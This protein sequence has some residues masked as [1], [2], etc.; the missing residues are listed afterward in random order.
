[1]SER[2]HGRRE[3]MS[4][5]AVFL[6]QRLAAQVG[7][8]GAIGAASRRQQQ[9]TRWS[10]DGASR[11]RE[12]E[13]SVFFGHWK[14]SLRKGT[15]GLRRCEVAPETL[16]EA[17]STESNSTR[18]PFLGLYLSFKTQPTQS[19]QERRYKIKC[20]LMTQ[21]EAHPRSRNA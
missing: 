6:R 13:R 12:T 21:K 5:S 16:G 17:Q 4:E 14:N 8:Q 15:A 3:R 2:R 20:G 11:G 18:K 19:Q 1:M 9:Q 10:V 7:G